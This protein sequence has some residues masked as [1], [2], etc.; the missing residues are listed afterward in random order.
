MFLMGKVTDS[1]GANAARKVRAYREDTGALVGETV[2]LASTG[3]YQIETTYDGEHT[4]LIYPLPTETALN[5][6][7]FRGVIPV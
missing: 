3:A 7:A 4:V 1:F 2:S 5:V 6:L